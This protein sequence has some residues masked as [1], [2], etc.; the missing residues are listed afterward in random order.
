MCVDTTSGFFL[1]SQGTVKMKKT[2]TSVGCRC[3]PPTE[4]G[5]FLELPVA[6]RINARIRF[7]AAH[8]APEGHLAPKDALDGVKTLVIEGKHI[9]YIGLSGPGDPLAYIEPTL[10]TLGL[11]HQ[12]FPQIPFFIRT[13]GLG[14][15]K[16]ADKLSKAGVSH[17][18]LQVNA[19]SEEIVE[20]IYAWVRP[21]YKTLRLPDSAKILISEQKR[22]VRAFKDAKMTVSVITTVFPEN[23]SDHIESIA[24]DMGEYGADNMVLVPYHPEEGAEIR[25]SVPNKKLM[26]A[27]RKKAAKYIGVADEQRPSL[28]VCEQR[29]MTSQLPKPTP[30]RP[31]VAIVSSNGM[32]IDLHLGAAV[33]VLIYGPRQDGLTCLLERRAAPEPGGGERRWESLAATLHDCFAVLAASAGDSPKKIL[34][35]SGIKILIIEDTIEGT[36][37]VLYGGGRKKKKPQPTAL[38]KKE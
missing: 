32:D 30:V 23:N 6:P 35:A 15:E 36:V 9:D 19:V 25:L 31:N 27:V 12:N 29:I 38:P 4:K 34:A 13:L 11:L 2:V 16:Y 3:R 1:L 20:K 18:D 21:G 8:Q 5:H 17:V 33:Q 10:E 14:G 37:D 22:A 26:E 24:H 28:F 7:S